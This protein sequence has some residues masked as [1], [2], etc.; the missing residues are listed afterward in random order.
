MRKPAMNANTVVTRPVT[1]LL[2]VE[3]SIDYHSRRAHIVPSS[4]IAAGYCHA[5]SCGH[6]A[7]T[8]FVSTVGRNGKEGRGVMKPLQ[9]QWW[10]GMQKCK[11]GTAAAC[12]NRWKCAV[13]MWLWVWR[14]RVCYSSVPFRFPF[15]VAATV[16]PLFE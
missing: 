2:R 14:P 3:P 10:G 11:K 6:A 9:K 13:V 16:W 5:S 1:Q 12:I 4:P 7:A 15:I 8:A